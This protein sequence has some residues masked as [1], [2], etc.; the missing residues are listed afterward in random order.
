MISHKMMAKI[1]C[2]NFEKSFLEREKM[3]SR[4]IFR[5]FL[6]ANFFMF[7]LIGN[8]TVLSLNLKLICTCEFF[9]KLKLHSPKQFVQISA[10]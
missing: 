1:V 2:G 6:H 10:F 5:H 8:H 7:V 4:K 3:A 9:K